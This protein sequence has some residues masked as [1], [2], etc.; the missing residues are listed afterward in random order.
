M[1]IVKQY[2]RNQDH[3]PTSD[4]EQDEPGIVTIAGPSK[5]VSPKKEKVWL[6]KATFLRI[7]K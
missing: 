4:I 6:S 1:L 5:A 3:V 2:Q 7:H